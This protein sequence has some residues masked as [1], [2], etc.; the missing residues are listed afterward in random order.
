MI[1][2]NTFAFPL[3]VH[4]LSNVKGRTV[5]VVRQ[6]EVDRVTYQ[7]LINEKLILIL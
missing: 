2:V 6:F 7:R 5:Y 4:L 1:S 3:E